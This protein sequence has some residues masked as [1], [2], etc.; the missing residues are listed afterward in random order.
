VE[1][2]YRVSATV[3]EDRLKKWFTSISA[4][5]RGGS[6]ISRD[7]PRCPKS[8]NAGTEMRPQCIYVNAIQRRCASARWRDGYGLR[9]K[10]DDDRWME[11]AAMKIETDLYGR[12]ASFHLPRKK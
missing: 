6:K 3:R 2:I 9:Q 7:H 10:S 11:A 4:M 1:E 5:E 8:R 12:S